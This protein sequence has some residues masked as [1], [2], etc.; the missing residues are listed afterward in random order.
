M[1]ERAYI[2]LA[3]DAGINTTATSSPIL[4]TD[5][6]TQEV[7][8]FNNNSL[9][10]NGSTETIPTPQ[11]AA[12]VAAITTESRTNRR[13]GQRLRRWQQNQHRRI[14]K[15]SSKCNPLSRHSHQHHHHHQLTSHDRSS[16][17]ASGS[18]HR[19]LHRRH[20]GR[21]FKPRTKDLFDGG[22]LLESIATS[23]MEL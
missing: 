15:P 4:L 2:T 20:H 9:I 18:S 3:R 1:D 12:V 8:H 10:N 21:T 19:R 16:R 6:F 7:T 23:S 11:G 14:S 22:N 13:H 17:L 5:N